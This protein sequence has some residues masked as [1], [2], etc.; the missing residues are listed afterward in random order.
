MV[1]WCALCISIVFAYDR[2]WQK[3]YVSVFFLFYIHNFVI[4]GVFV[5]YCLLLLLYISTHFCFVLF[6]K[7][8]WLGSTHCQLQIFRFYHSALIFFSR[9]CSLKDNYTWISMVW[10]LFVSVVVV[11]VIV[12][13]AFVTVVATV[14]GTTTWYYFINTNCILKAIEQ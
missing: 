14:V 13:V 3:K 11:I 6:W 2:R 4:R 8:Y 7:S 5:I 9:K 1:V 10:I 12:V